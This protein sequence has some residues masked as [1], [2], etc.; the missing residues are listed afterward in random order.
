MR[1]RRAAGDGVVRDDTGVDPD[2]PAKRHIRLDDDDE[3]NTE[4]GNEDEDGDGI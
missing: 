1:P 4:G 2:E 3:S